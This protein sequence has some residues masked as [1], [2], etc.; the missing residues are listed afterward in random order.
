MCGT[1]GCGEGNQITIR[2]PGEEHHAHLHSHDHNHE[3]DHSHDHTHSHYH[4]HDH[5]REI[6][7]EIDVLNKNNLLAERNRGYFEAKNITALNL[8]SSPGS[9]KTSLLERTIKELNNKRKLYVVE[10][11]QQTMND[12][13]RINSAGAPVIQV[14]TGSGCHL[15]A[16]M[17]NSAVK[18][19]EV[20]DESILFIENVGNLVCPSMFDLGESKRV[21]VISVTEGEDKPIK[22]PT[23][24]ETAQ[25]CIINKTDL[26]PYVDFNVEK[27]KEYAMSVNH[28]LE[29]IE[30]SVKTG[31]GMDIWYKWLE[32][33]K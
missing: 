5:N 21:V 6:Q 31:E 9:G 12:A 8:V 24:F 32:N 14:N 23:M 25:L 19:L 30:V 11:D 33:V 4:N 15:D 27:A 18:E 10:G 1:C 3:H 28:H 2:K 20:Q 17:I 7:L 22:Y 13:D 26:L 16:E 29:F